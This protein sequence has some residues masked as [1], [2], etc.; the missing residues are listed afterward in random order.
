MGR[1][2]LGAF[3]TGLLYKKTAEI[4]MTA[5]D[6]RNYEK[7]LDAEALAGYFASRRVL[8]ALTGEFP[9]LLPRMGL[10]AQG[11]AQIDVNDTSDTLHSQYLELRLTAELLDPLH[12]DV[13]ALGELVQGPEGIQR[14]AAVSAEVDW[15]T[16]GPWNDLLSAKFLWTSGRSGSGVSAFI[17]VGGV[18]AGSVFDPGLRALM[19][20]GLSYR[21]RPLAGFSAGAGINYFIRTDLETLGDADLD[22]A[23]DSRLLGGELSGSLTWAPDPAFMLTAGAGAFFP[24]WG[25]AFREDAPVRWKLN[26]G[27][28]V[29][30]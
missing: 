4:V 8:L 2:S 30:L 16:P 19:S 29:S 27:L 22:D 11:L 23:S 9:A 17:P 6:Q 3:Y 24:R 10:T 15:E 5:N 21:A 25:G 1:F 12:L 14:S 28:L 26:L 13:G 18:T 7:P 20:A